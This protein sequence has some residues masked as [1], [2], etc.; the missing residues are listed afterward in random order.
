MHLLHLRKCRFN[1]PRAPSAH[2]HGGRAICSSERFGQSALRRRARPGVKRTLAMPLARYARCQVTY[3]GRASCPPATRRRSCSGPSWCISLR[4]VPRH[5]R[6]EPTRIRQP[7]PCGRRRLRPG[8][9]VSFASS[10]CRVHVSPPPPSPGRGVAIPLPRPLDGLGDQSLNARCHTQGVAC[11]SAAPALGL[12]SRPQRSDS[13]PESPYRGATGARIR[14]HLPSSMVYGRRAGM[15]WLGYERRLERRGDDS[16]GESMKRRGQRHAFP[17][18][19]C[20][21]AVL[22]TPARTS[23]RCLKFQARSPL[24]PSVPPSLR[25]S[26]PPSL[27]PSLLSLPLI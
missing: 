1:A 11:V 17:S 5:D 12:E 19:R 13:R 27:R 21:D 26:V 2:M 9:L 8:F 20:G 25:P 3:P 24:R 6:R 23:S 10:L 22:N 14:A 18:F 15:V 7:L 4:P 16:N